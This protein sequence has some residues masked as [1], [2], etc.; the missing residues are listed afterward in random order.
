M[1]KTLIF[2]TSAL[3]ALFV[4]G[5]S[6]VLAQSQ[7][8]QLPSAGLTPAS[9]L[10]SLDR[11]GEAVRELFTFSADGKARIQIE[12]TAERVAELKTELK[13]D[14]PN[15][16]TIEIAL[17]RIQIHIMRAD[18]IIKKLSRKGE[19]IELLAVAIHSQFNPLINILRD[20]INSIQDRSS[21]ATEER[22]GILMKGIEDSLDDILKDPMEIEEAVKQAI[23][24]AE[25]K[26]QEILVEADKTGLKT[27]ARELSQF[28][29]FLAQA[30]LSLA[31]GNVQEARRLI[32]LAEQRLEYLE[33]V[34]EEAKK[35]KKF[36]QETEQQ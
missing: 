4:L 6:T 19:D 2:S 25:N 30:K 10:Y 21:Q 12:F 29:T 7:L 26:R 35:L 23:R 16:Q 14:D 1:K 28:D 5:G 17:M 22:I 27:T 11:F 3:A 36:I 8:V 9:P 15:I 31:N 18:D 34:Q 20:T 24:E 32:R 33:N 13:K